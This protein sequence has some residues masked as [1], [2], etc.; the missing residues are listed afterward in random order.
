[1]SRGEG[2]KE[3]TRPRVGMG[4]Q[5][6]IPGCPRCFHPSPP[7]RGPRSCAEPQKKRSGLRPA[8][9]LSAGWSPADS[10]CPEGEKERENLVERDPSPAAA[11]DVAPGGPAPSGRTSPAPHGEERGHPSTVGPGTISSSPDP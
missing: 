4:G 7:L 3:G 2:D 11:A 10:I 9:C 5:G 6:A 1:M 8:R